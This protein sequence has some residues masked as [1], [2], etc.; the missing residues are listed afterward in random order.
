[1]TCSILTETNEVLNTEN[2]EP[3]TLEACSGAT[4][5]LS[6][7]SG[8]ENF[9]SLILLP[10][11]IYFDQS[12]TWQTNAYVEKDL[13]I[14]YDVG[15]GIL[16][17]YRIQGAC[18]PCAYNNGC[19]STGLQVFGTSCLGGSTGYQFLIQNVLASNLK[20]VCQILQES[21]LNWQVCTIKVYSR[22]ADPALSG[23]EDVCNTLLDVPFE[24]LPECIPIYVQEKPF[25]KMRL[26]SYAIEANFDFESTG[27][28]TTGGA[29]L[30]TGS[31]GP[32]SSFDYVCGTYPGLLLGSETTYTSSWD[33]VPLIQMKLEAS[34]SYV[35]AELNSKDDELVLSGLSSNIRTLCGT[36]TSMPSSL[37]AFHNLGDTV[38]ITNFLNRNFVSLPDK[39]LM[40]YNKRTKMWTSNYQMIGDGDYGEEKW[41]FSFNWYCMDFAYIENVEE[42]YVS[43]FWKF[44]IFVNR[45][46]LDQN[47]DFDTKIH[48]VFP[49]DY[50]CDQI[51]NLTVNFPFSLNTTTKYVSNNFVEVTEDVVLADNIKLFSSNSWKS[52]PQ[53]NITLSQDTNLLVSEKLDLTPTIP[54]EA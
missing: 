10:E 9:G 29:A 28:I 43:P 19:E 34:L 35:E 42:D 44:S 49:P 40:K 26:K 2:L 14:I 41:S 39:F 50:L 24:S 8:G 11:Y 6:G 16:K 18:Q 36:C 33:S 25:V 21:K 30:I 46:Y 51:D 22:P 5:Q 7:I 52:N 13:D 48:I 4:L 17:W 15:Q 32:S 53:L 3:L 1:M 27:E 45:F 38:E 54:T 47:L 37:Y 20:E 23:P 12:I 31:T